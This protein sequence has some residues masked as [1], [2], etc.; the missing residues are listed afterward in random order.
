MHDSMEPLVQP[1]RFGVG[2][3]H[4]VRRGRPFVSATN[5]HEKRHMCEQWATQK[6]PKFAE[7]AQE[8]LEISDFSL[9]DLLDCVS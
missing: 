3:A 5:R 4:V 2:V 8:I 9:P 7:I 6:A 1:T